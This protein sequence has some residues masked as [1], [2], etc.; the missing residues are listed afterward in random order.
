M[1][2]NILS[3]LGHAS[4]PNRS[5][6]WRLRQTGAIWLGVAFLAALVWIRTASAQTLPCSQF[7]L[8]GVSLN[9]CQSFM[10]APFISTAAPTDAIQ[11]ATAV[12]RSAGYKE[13]S[14]TAI[15]FGQRFAQGRHQFLGLAGHDTIRIRREQLGAGGGNRSP[16]HDHLTRGPRPHR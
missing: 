8:D 16:D 1:N 13:L 3:I 4:P 7:A 6:R 14:I 11:M 5:L 10:S 2:K 9:L 15:P 12:D